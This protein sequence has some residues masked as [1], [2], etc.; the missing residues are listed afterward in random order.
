MSYRGASNWP[1]VWLQNTRGGVKT[2][3][4]EIGV[5]KYVFLRH[6]PADKCYLTMEYQNQAFVGTMLFDDEAFCERICRILRSHVGHAI[7]EIG[8]LELPDTV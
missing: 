7:K 2:L 8:D 6:A 3:K 4:G 5:L 1:P